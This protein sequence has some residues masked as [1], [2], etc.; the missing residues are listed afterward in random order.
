MGIFNALQSRA[1]VPPSDGSNKPTLLGGLSDAAADPVRS[2]QQLAQASNTGDLPAPTPGEWRIEMRYLPIVDRGH[3][4]LALIGPDD[5]TRR[6][7]HGLSYSRNTPEGQPPVY[8]P[9]GPDG[10]RLLAKHFRDVSPFGE[11]LPRVA[12][13]ARGL[14]DDIVRGKWARGVQTAEE[15]DKRDFDYKGYDPSYVFGGSGGQ[16]QNSNSAAYTFGRTMGLDLDSAIRSARLE[17]TF[18]GWDR[19][20]LD[21]TY[22]RYVAPPIFA[23]MNAP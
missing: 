12:E 11:N 2:G 17:R 16:I 3:T 23:N 19:N 10:S 15:I 5:R 14:Y 6:E 21:P 13:V 22:K 1:Y 20:L 8:L 4:F 9:I 7:L 18:P